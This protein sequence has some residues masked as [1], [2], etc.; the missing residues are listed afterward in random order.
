MDADRADYRAFLD[1]FGIDDE[2]ITSL[3]HKTDDLTPFPDCYTGIL[4]FNASSIEGIGLF[5][6]R[7]IIGGE[8]FAPARLDGMRTPGGRF[9]NHA[10][11]PNS[12]FEPIG[13]DLWLVANRDIPEGEEITLDYREALLTNIGTL[14]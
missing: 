8:T 10:I 2:V 4:R 6:N 11:S 13:K 14:Q 12:R 1:E 3:L 5:A 9:V 7:R